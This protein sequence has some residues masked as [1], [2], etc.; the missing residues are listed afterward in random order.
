MRRKAKRSHMPLQPGDVLAT[1][2]DASSLEKATGFRPKIPVEIGVPR[3]V[4][5]YREFYRA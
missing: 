4:Q 3:F 5:W 1:Y 2:A